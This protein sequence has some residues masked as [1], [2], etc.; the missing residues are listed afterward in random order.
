[1]L[2]LSLPDLH[3]F[4][5]YQFSSDP[6]ERQRRKFIAVNENFLVT[7]AWVFMYDI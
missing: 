1:M 4:Y 6:I 5:E 2:Q 3:D 7:K